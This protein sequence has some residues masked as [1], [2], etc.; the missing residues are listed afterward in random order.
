MALLPGTCRGDGPHLA[1]LTDGT[2]TL[3]STE[4]RWS[5][6]GLYRTTADRVAEWP[7]GHCHWTP[8]ASTKAGRSDPAGSPRTRGRPRAPPS[9]CSTRSPPLKPPHANPG[10]SP[11]CRCT[12]VNGPGAK[13]I[14]LNAFVGD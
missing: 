5:T 13:L 3:A 11:E 4:H 2:A 10:R 8:T 7:S 1:A 12:I 14:R 6:L 9:R